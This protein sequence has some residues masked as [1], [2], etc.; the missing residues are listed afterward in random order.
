MAYDVVERAET[1]RRFGIIAMLWGTIMALIELFILGADLSAM[2]RLRRDLALL[3]SSG[4]LSLIG[5]GVVWTFST[6]LK[7]RPAALTMSRAI[8]LAVT[9]YGIVWFLIYVMAYASQRS[10]SIN[11]IGIG[12]A[13][14]TTAALVG[15]CRRAHEEADKVIMDL[16]NTITASSGID[17]GGA[18]YASRPRS[19]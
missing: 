14:V 7:R 16:L 18:V 13:G 8:F 15:L 3:G 5:A 1:I 10:A 6:A 4:F 19:G 2:E 12:V 9:G 17:P 11:A